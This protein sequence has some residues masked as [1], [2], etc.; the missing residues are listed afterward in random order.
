MYLS[1]LTSA[2]YSTIRTYILHYN[3]DSALEICENI[4]WCSGISGSEKQ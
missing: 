1:D 4:L 3:G 2:L